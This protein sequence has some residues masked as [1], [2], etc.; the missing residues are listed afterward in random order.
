MR[1]ARYRTAVLKSAKSKLR[2]VKHVLCIQR[3]WRARS[4]VHRKREEVN[5]WVD[6]KTKRF[7]Q[8][9]REGS[10]H[11]EGAGDTERNEPPCLPSEETV[12]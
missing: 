5:R 11:A 9:T 8:D 10:W 4:S 2:H 3:Y 6:S 7:L 1:E 12:T